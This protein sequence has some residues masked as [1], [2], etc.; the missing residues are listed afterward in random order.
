MGLVHGLLIN[1]E[2]N[3]SMVYH[4]SID[5]RKVASEAFS[6]Y[7]RAPGS[8]LFKG[9]KIYSISSSY[10][11]EKEKK[12]TKDDFQKTFSCEFR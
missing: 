1:K 9:Y 3:F 7:V 11:P 6:T 8:R 10:N 4:A 12:F 5:R 2:N